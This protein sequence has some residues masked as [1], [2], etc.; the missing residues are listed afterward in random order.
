[1]KKNILIILLISITGC[2]TKYWYNKPGVTVEQRNKDFYECQ[3]QSRYQQTGAA[4]NAYGGYA[5]SSQ[6][7]DHNLVQS[8]L[9]AR[10]YRVEDHAF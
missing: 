7:V 10:G 3:M 8:C 5:V 1:M 9:R 4:L 2:A 6:V